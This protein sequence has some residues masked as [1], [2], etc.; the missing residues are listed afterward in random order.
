M[1][2]L[3]V[4]INFSRNRAAYLVT[5]QSNMPEE[6]SSKCFMDLYTEYYPYFNNF[7]RRNVFIELRIN[8]QASPAVLNLLCSSGTAAINSRLFGT[9]QKVLV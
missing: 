5:W 1:L 7:K 2:I 6:Q 8:L 9:D 3:G 4:I